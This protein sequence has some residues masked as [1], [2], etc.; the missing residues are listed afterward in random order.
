M[1]ISFP[2][3]DLSLNFLQQREAPQIR[4]VGTTVYSVPL[5]QVFDLIFNLITLRIPEKKGL[6]KRTIKL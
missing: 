1:V 2:R 6:D 5:G 4:V 3:V